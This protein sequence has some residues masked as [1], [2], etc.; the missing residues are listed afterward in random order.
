[1]RYVRL[2]FA[3]TKRSLMSKFIYK[4]NTFV[5]IIG[6]L[7]VEVSSL[8]TL[9]LLIDVV[10]SLDGYTKYQIG[11][12]FAFT[13]IA[14]GIDH[15]F[16]D[17]LWKVAYWEVKDGKLD[18][19]FLRP[20]P[21]LFQVLASTIQLE[22]LGELLVATGLLIVCSSYVTITM[23]FGNILLLIVGVVCASIIIASFKIL[24]TSFA[25]I[26]K[27]SGALLQF[28]YNFATYSK[29]PLKIFPSVIRFILMFIIPLGICIFI[30]FDSLFN[31][32]YNPYIL[33][34]CILGI[35]CLFTVISL[36]VWTIC[37]KKYESTGS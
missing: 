26:F 18:H 21:I 13:N 29:Y 30:P 22:A 25:F 23:T 8:L 10:P 37:A 11:M 6:F 14:I 3:Y 4:A 28:I 34:L 32:T 16:T 33:C 17:R 27:R 31:P 1:M 24:V 12:L 19:M 36:Y 5:G 2:Y 35:T 7:F 9:Y 15:L 20:V